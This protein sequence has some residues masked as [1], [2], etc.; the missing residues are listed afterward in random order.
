MTVNSGFDLDNIMLCPD[1]FSI[2]TPNLNPMTPEMASLYL[3][4][5]KLTI[6]VHTQKL[7]LMIG[8]T[9]RHRMESIMKKVKNDL[10]SN[11][12]LLRQLKQDNITRQNNITKMHRQYEDKLIRINC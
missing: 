4:M 7:R 8:R 12:Q 6:E 5:E 10:I 11:K 3:Q 1:L 2:E 9:K